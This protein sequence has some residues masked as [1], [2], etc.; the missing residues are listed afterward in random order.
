MNNNQ[1]KE[2]K[3]ENQ[4]DL[5]LDLTDKLMTESIR[6]ITKD[7][8]RGRLRGAL[9]NDENKS[10]VV[11]SFKAIDIIREISK[12]GQSETAKSDFLDLLQD[13]FEEI[14][15]YDTKVGVLVSK[16]LEERGLSPLIERINA[17]FLRY[18][19]ERVF[20]H[21]KQ[22]S[23]N[24]FK[25][26]LKIRKKKIANKVINAIKSFLEVYEKRQRQINIVKG[27]ANNVKNWDP[28]AGN[29]GLY[30]EEARR[31][32]EALRSLKDKSID[33]LLNSE[34][35]KRIL[36]Y[37]R[38][39]ILLND[40]LRRISTAVREEKETWKDFL[41]VYKNMKHIASAIEEKYFD[42]ATADELR[43]CMKDQFKYGEEPLPWIAKFNEII[44]RLQ[45]RGVTISQS[46][47]VLLDLFSKVIIR[48]KEINQTEFT[49]ARRNIAKAVSEMKELPAKD[50]K[51][52]LRIAE[53]RE[54]ELNKELEG[55]RKNYDDV[56]ESNS[57]GIASRFYE[58]VGMLTKIN[59]S[60]LA[61][62]I[63]DINV[64][65]KQLYRRGIAVLSA[66]M[67]DNVNS[68]KILSDNRGPLLV[69]ENALV[70]KF[71]KSKKIAQEGIDYQMPKL[72]FEL[73]RVI[74]IFEKHLDYLIGVLEKL[75]LKD[76]N[77]RQKERIAA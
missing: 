40:V 37:Q 24:Y 18:P 75:G 32:V 43:A 74:P 5:I 9:F 66:V 1:I 3:N 8:K 68:F 48:V 38:E 34:V 22:Y 4:I 57:V 20:E 56:L 21:F 19:K 63:L 58:L 50:R 71:N 10:K 46:Q 6:L 14:N 44:S 55:I 30:I 77:F 13:R 61:K 28:Y 76:E 73:R 45:K 35:I 42:K 52:L 51:L 15:K 60:L 39:L 69:Y 27:F 64:K 12:T 47:L 17:I 2:E 70:D 29:M 49:Q 53:R 7:Q 41:N 33:L 59:P 54:K 25:R 16:M 11:P 67:N 26:L 72:A 62:C 65:K 31:Y 23:Q 36:S